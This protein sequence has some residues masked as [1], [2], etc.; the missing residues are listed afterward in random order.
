MSRVARHDA[1]TL[2]PRENHDARIDDV[3]RTGCTA[4]HAGPLCFCEV[5]RMDCDEPRSKKPC[6]PHL[7]APISPYLPN[8]SGWSMQRRARSKS[9]LYERTNF[10]IIALKGDECSSIEHYRPSTS[11]AHFSSSSVAGP[12][13][14][15]ISARREASSSRRAFSSIAASTHAL[16]DLARPRFTC[17]SAFAKIS[18][19]TVTVT[20]ARCIRKSYSVDGFSARSSAKVR[21]WVPDGHVSCINAKACVLV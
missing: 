8:D 3:A 18:R 1:C 15:R 21:R 6:K 20:R 2:T 12:F 10:T 4:N 7:A 14:A 13:S 11:R 5:E 17:R 19:R 16:T 9:Q